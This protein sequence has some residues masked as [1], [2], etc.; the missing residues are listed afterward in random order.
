MIE[1]KKQCDFSELYPELWSGAVETVNTVIENG[2]T[3][4][5]MQLLEEIFYEPTNITTINDFLWFDSDFIFEQLEINDL[6]KN[7]SLKN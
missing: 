2:K 6:T 5:L 3:G 4:E 1:I 7:L